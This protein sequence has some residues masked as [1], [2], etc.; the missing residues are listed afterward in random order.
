MNYAFNYARDHAMVLGSEYP[1]NGRDNACGVASGTGNIRPTGYVN[2]ARYSPKALMDA[3]AIT[4]IA[5]A[6]RAGTS[7]FGYYRSG[8]LTDATACGTGVDHAVVLVGWGTTDAG[9]PYWLMKNSW[10]TGWGDNGYFKVLRDMSAE[11]TP[12]VCYIYSYNSYPKF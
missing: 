2:V 8:V 1:Y 3:L 12:G 11:N 5:L 9:T 6:L 4:P 10:G 7:Y